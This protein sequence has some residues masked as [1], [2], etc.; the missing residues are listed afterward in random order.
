MEHLVWGKVEELLTQPEFVLSELIRQ[1][2]EAQQSSTVETDLSH[3]KDRLT[4]LDNEQE[5]LLEHSLMGF[6]EE[7]VKKQNKVINEQRQQLLE[8]QKELETQVHSKQQCQS[9]LGNIET[10]CHLI[11]ENIKLL[12]F[13]NKRLALE[14]LEIKVWVD[15][16]NVEIAGSIPMN[17][18]ASTVSGCKRPRT[19]SCP[20]PWWRRR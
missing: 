4:E 13:D 2:Q 17:D 16:N 1:Q 3:F 19:Q 6:P 14:A 9:N 8:L 5:R 12:S 11:K 18:I 7:L 15:D 20:C 10:F